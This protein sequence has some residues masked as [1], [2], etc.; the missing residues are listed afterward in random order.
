MNPSA[1]K[2]PLAK[3]CIHWLT[4]DCPKGEPSLAALIGLA[5]HL[6]VALVLGDERLATG[7]AAL[8]TKACEKYGLDEATHK[9]T[10]LRMR[11]V[12]V[13][14]ELIRAHITV[15][16]ERSFRF[17]TDGVEDLGTMIDREYPDAPGVFG[18]LDC[19]WTEVD[20]DTHA[21]TLVVRD[22]KT[23]RQQNTGA[24]KDNQQLRFLAYCA[25]MAQPQAAID[26]VRVELAYIS[27]DGELSID[28]HT[29]LAVELEDYPSELMAMLNASQE[30]RPQNH[31]RNQYCP[32]IAYCKAT[33]EAEEEIAPVEAP[34]TVGGKPYP[35]RVT[36]A[37]EIQSIDHASWLLHRVRAVEAAC[38]MM[39]SA[40]RE[41]SK[42][43]PIPTTEGKVWGPTLASTESIVAPATKDLSQ[44][45]GDLLPAEKVLELAETRIGKGE[46]EKLC[47]DTAPPRQGAK[48][49]REV[50][51]A[52]K[53][54]GVVRMGSKE[55][56]TERAVEERKAS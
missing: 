14:L 55:T 33:T 40:L 3:H 34:L 19:E 35:L 4:L 10:L 24:A 15:R 37:S 42:V 11:P 25:L 23:G 5:W 27:E 26:E 53:S 28:S 22:W 51:A 18:T 48:L 31:C 29:Y 8:Y 47:K 20:H 7:P 45:V 30:P 9:P 32:A 56:W 50:M 44:C 39:R 54:H 6:I 38:E 21:M 52:L 16:A 12:E 2:L 36:Q 13:A 43:T 1:S 41:Y 46:L 49:M 17:S